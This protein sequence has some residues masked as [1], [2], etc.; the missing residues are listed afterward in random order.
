MAR[1]KGADVLSLDE[2]MGDGKEGALVDVVL[3]P[4]QVSFR[5]TLRVVL[6]VPWNYVCDLIQVSPKLQEGRQGEPCR[7]RGSEQLIE[8]KS[9]WERARGGGGGGLSCCSGPGDVSSPNPEEPKKRGGGR[10]SS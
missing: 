7:F 5:T 6:R 4:G 9:T 8:P 1:G 3:E 10:G 2:V